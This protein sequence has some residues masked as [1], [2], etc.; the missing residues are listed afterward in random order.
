MVDMAGPGANAC[1][2]RFRVALVDIRCCNC[3]GNGGGTAGCLHVILGDGDGWYF[4]IAEGGDG[5]SHGCLDI[6]WLGALG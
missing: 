4:L 1:D 5:D 3:F 6:V 2:A